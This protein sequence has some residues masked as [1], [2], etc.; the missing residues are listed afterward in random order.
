L[1]FKNTPSTILKKKVNTPKIRIPN[2]KLKN[3]TPRKTAKRA[4]KDLKIGQPAASPYSA[5][6]PKNLRPPGD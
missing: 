2:L 6:P 3:K 1:V 4:T 5:P